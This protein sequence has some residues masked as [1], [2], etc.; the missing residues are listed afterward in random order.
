MHATRAAVEEGIVPGGGTALLRCRPA[1]EK[2]TER[3][4][5]PFGARGGAPWSK[6][7]PHAFCFLQILNDI[8]Q[9]TRLRIATCSEH[10]H[11][12]LR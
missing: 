7:E 11:Q 6:F 8:K 5:S 2:L 9:I 12:T 4:L 3:A 10:S 1:L